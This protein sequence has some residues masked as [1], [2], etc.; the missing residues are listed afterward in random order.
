MS[1]ATTSASQRRC[2]R[3][4]AAALLLLICAPFAAAEFALYGSHARIPFV[5]EW[6]LLQYDEPLTGAS[7]RI[8]A[9]GLMFDFD[10]DA[11]G[12]LY[13]SDGEDLH[14]VDL[15][16]GEKTEIGAFDQGGVTTSLAFAP[17]GTLVGV[18][19]NWLITIHP[20]TAE[21]LADLVPVSFDGFQSFDGLDYGV[22]GVLRAVGLE[23]GPVGK[24]Y[25]FDLDGGTLITLGDTTEINPQAIAS[26]PEPATA[27]LAFL[28][29]AL[30]TR[31]R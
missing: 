7:T 15:A 19:Q 20:A 9:G 26:I 2:A 25:E 13:S 31:R 3:C 21:T 18:R 5:N 6:G 8:G 24:L 27:S 29:L 10:F 30:V 28:T 12:V 23:D 22:D 11:D 16:T 17:D 14:T 1:N 4:L